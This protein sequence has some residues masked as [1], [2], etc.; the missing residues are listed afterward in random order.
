[1]STRESDFGT[2]ETRAQ[3]GGIEVGYTA[4]GAKVGKVRYQN[5][6]DKL[7]VLESIS[8]KQWQAGDRLRS[9][10]NRAG[11]FAEI[12][13]SAD[14]DPRGNMTDYAADALIDAQRKYRDI[15]SILDNVGKYGISERAVIQKIVVDDGYLKD[16]SR[17]AVKLR[18]VR[19]GLFSGLDKLIRHYRV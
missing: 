1:M 8:L 10:A 16:F 6:F 2:D 18:H 19:V 12:R 11:Q 4:E 17:S 9:D 5:H 13:S 3:A 14:A 15:L 7:L